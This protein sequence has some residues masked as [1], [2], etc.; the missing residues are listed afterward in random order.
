MRVSSLVLLKSYGEQIQ[1]LMLVLFVNPVGVDAPLAAD[2]SLCC[3][4]L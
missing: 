3:F 1:I 4:C 2:R